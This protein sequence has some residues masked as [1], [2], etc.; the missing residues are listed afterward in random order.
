MRRDEV[1][2]LERGRMVKQSNPGLYVTEYDPYPNL[3]EAC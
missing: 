1:I 2:G 3:G